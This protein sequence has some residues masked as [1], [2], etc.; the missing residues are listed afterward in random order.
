MIESYADTNTERLA[1]GFRVPEFIAFERVAL[2]KIRQLQAASTLEDLRVPPGNRLESLKGDRAGEYSIRINGQYRICFTW[3][4][5]Y[6]GK[7]EIV[8][9]HG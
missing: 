6:A 5:G 2:R 1:K 7:V 3:R 9:Y 8:D 4:V